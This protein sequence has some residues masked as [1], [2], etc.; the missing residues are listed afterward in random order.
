ME[1]LRIYNPVSFAS[2]ACVKDATVGGFKVP[3]G[4]TVHVNFRNAHLCPAHFPDPHS[5]KPDRF[6]D[7]DAPDN[8]AACTPFG[9]GGRCC[10]G[11]A[12]QTA[13][14]SR[15]VSFIG[16]HCCERSIAVRTS[17]GAMSCVLHMPKCDTCHVFGH[18]CS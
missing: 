10:P 5:F 6:L 8:L 11:C 12:L 4:S 7:P 1:M 2:R 15:C 13:V 16:A 14:S 3:K 17:A 18:D 9:I